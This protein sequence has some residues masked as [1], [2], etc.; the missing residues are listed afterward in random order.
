MRA[1]VVHEVG[2]GVVLQYLTLAQHK[3]FVAL[4]DRVEAVSNC[5]DSR[6]GERNVDQF[7][8]LLLGHNINVSSGFIEHNH[9]VLPQYGS[10]NANQLPLTRREIFTTFRDLHVKTRR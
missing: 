10:T 8:D 5:D 9:L 2:R 3:H 1:R 4:N 7:L 6:V